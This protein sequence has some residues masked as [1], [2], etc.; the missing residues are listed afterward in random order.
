MKNVII[1]DILLK[2]VL[3]WMFQH[4]PVPIPAQ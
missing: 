4:S 3:G 2:E 1:N